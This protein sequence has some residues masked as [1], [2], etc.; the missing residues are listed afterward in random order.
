MLAVS[1]IVRGT[2]LLSV[3]RR[4]LRLLK[5]FRIAP[6]S[7]PTTCADSLFTRRGFVIYFSK[8]NGLQ[9]GNQTGGREMKTNIFNLLMHVVSAGVLI[10]LVVLMFNPLARPAQ[11]PLWLV[12]LY[13]FIL[14]VVGAIIVAVNA[15]LFKIK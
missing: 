6:K 14:V 5:A 1:Y 12:G 15:K 9:S 4:D 11:A 10:V 8:P 2:V 3:F 13:Y 7:R